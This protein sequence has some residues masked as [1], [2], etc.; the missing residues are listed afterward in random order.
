[1]HYQKKRIIHSRTCRG[2]RRGNFP[3]SFQDLGKIQIF[4]AVKGKYFGKT[5]KFLGQGHEK[6]G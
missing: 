4:R 2:G 5:N 1:M 3:P 6:F